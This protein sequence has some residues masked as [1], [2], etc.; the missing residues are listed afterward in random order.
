MQAGDGAFTELAADEMVVL[1]PTFGHLEPDGETW[2][3][4]VAGAVLQPDQVKLGSRIMIRMLRR[5]M[6]V[7]AEALLTDIFRQ[8]IRDFAASTQGGKQIA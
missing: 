8:R 2:R 6:K 3:V 5:A 1:Y 7:T 4:A